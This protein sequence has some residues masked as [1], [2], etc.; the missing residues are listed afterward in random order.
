M[1]I[2]FKKM[3]KKESIKKYYY[4]V[5]PSY[6]IKGSLVYSSNTILE[7]GS[8]VRVSLRKKVVLGCVIKILKNPPNMNF[9]VKDILEPNYIYKLNRNIID[10]LYWVSK[11]NLCNLG[12]V[13]KL[14][15]PKQLLMH[16]T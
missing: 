15:L 8:I 12:T 14:I 11:Y 1:L 6:N 2:L 13:L 4:D 3:N 10:F 7:V 5:I 16:L 9:K